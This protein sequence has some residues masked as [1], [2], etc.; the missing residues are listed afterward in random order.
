MRCPQESSRLLH[1]LPAPQLDASCAG[2]KLPGTLEVSMLPL[3]AVPLLLAIP[4]SGCHSA[5]PGGQPAT[6]H[7][8]I[9][10]FAIEP[11]QEKTQCIVYRLDNLEGGYV[12]T[13]HADL[14]DRSHHMS[15]YKSAATEERRTPFAC[16]GFDSVLDGDQPL[17]IAQEARTDLAFPDDEHG[18]PVGF[19]IGPHQ[20]VRLELHYLNTTTSPGVGQGDY[21][22]GTVP[23][24]SAVVPADIGF[25]GTT[26]I[27]IPP[28]A[29]WKTDV[30]WVE[31]PS[32]THIFALTTH[33][34]GLG[35]RMRVWY[36]DDADDTAGAPLADCRTWSDPPIHV[37]SPPLVF[38][39]GHKQGLAYQC[40]W[41]NTTA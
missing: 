10:P 23:L 38:G 24:T 20:M 3:R 29:A 11:G 33:Q 39:P 32:G 28:H 40:E 36:A 41:M 9:G 13:I 4:L 6:L 14:G 16:R 35:T 25:W 12:R 37:F 22:L 26:D 1:P 17:F 8:S 5:G 19:E 18:T 31:A 30:K 2:A 27:H 15:L 7:A 21:V 34:H